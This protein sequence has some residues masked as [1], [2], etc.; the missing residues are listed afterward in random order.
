MNRIAS[1]FESIEPNQSYAVFTWF[2]Q[3]PVRNT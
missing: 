3:G 2:E 1:V